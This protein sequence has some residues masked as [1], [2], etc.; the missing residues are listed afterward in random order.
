M[1][2][3]NHS[4]VLNRQPRNTRSNRNSPMKGQIMQSRAGKRHHRNVSS[5]GSSRSSSQSSVPASNSSESQERETD[6]LVLERRQK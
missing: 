4:L 5:S 2:E 3:E 6:P 1:S